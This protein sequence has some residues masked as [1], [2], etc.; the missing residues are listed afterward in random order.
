MPPLYDEAPLFTMEDVA[1]HNAK[2]DAWVVVGGCV[3]DI[4]VFIRTHPGWTVAG[5]TSTILAITR[6][7]GTDCTEEWE[8]IHSK[9]AKAQLPQYFIGRLKVEGSGPEP[10]PSPAALRQIAYDGSEKVLVQMEGPGKLTAG[11][12]SLKLD[13]KKATLARLKQL[14]RLVFH[15]R[16]GCA[17][18]SIEA[19][20]VFIDGEACGDDRKTLDEL[21]VLLGQMGKVSAALCPL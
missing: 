6:T 17:L 2:E 16:L 12:A 18:P 14:L 15:S 4:T 9:T 1:A 21:G 10:P 13:T 20:R 19:V 5:Q 8:E 7:M 11:V 3:Y